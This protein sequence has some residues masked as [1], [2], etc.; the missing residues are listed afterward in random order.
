[1][2]LHDFLDYWARE[3]PNAEFAVHGRRRLTYGEAL[4]QANRLAHACIDAGLQIGDRVAVLAKNS[5]E[6]A[7][8]Y[9]GASKAGVVPVPLNY[10]LS[11]PEWRYIITDA[12]AKLLI[13]ARE[14]V[15][16]VH[17]RVISNPRPGSMRTDDRY[18]DSM[19]MHFS[20]G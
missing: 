19:L 9:Y 1:M 11:P 17:R 4:A 6:Y 15:A 8:L 7:L 5:L 18:A 2:R 14:Y 12:Q 13:A 16:A 3:R 10:R 20:A